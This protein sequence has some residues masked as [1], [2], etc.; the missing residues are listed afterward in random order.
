[1]LFCPLEQDCGEHESDRESTEDVNVLEPK[2]T[3]VESG[4]KAKPRG[5]KHEDRGKGK[6]KKTASGEKVAK[7]RGGGEPGADPF[8][9]S[10]EGSYKLGKGEG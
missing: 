2:K 7:K 3:K 6:G 5:K 9:G 1:M 10:G 4:P 8:S